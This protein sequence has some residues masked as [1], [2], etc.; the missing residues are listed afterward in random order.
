MLKVTKGLLRFLNE[1]PDGLKLFVLNVFVLLTA[2]SVG[3]SNSWS[4]HCVTLK[5]R[6]CNNIKGAMFC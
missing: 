1:R 2:T 3:I 5:T 6:M 4:R